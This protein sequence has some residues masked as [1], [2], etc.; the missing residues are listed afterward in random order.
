MVELVASGTLPPEALPPKYLEQ[1]PSYNYEKWIEALP[2]NI[3]TKVFQHVTH[4]SLPQAFSE[5]R[6]GDGGPGMPCSTPP[7]PPG[8]PGTWTGVGLRSSS[9]LGNC[10]QGSWLPVSDEAP[11][12]RG[13]KAQWPCEGVSPAGR[14]QGQRRALD[15]LLGQGSSEWPP[16]PRS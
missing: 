15:H 14:P 7:W 9:L 2:R 8:V 10:G 3:R 12:A 1:N 11:R 5:V 6:A 16:L 4:C 13:T